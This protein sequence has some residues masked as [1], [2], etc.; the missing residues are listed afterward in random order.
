MS[1]LNTE[2]WEKAAVLL[3]NDPERETDASLQSAYGLAL[4]R[5]GRAARAEEVL[6]RAAAAQGRLERAAG[7]AG[8]GPRGA[9][10]GE[11]A[12][13]AVEKAL[14]IHPDDPEAQRTLEAVLEARRA[15]GPRPRP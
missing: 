11:E 3:E 4:V 1:W 12:L 14:A 13:R 6:T 9:G 8:P 7:A 10:R 2:A 5:S 15:R